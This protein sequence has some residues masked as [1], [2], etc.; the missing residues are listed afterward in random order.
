MK[1]CT[2]SPSHKQERKEENKKRVVYIRGASCTHGVV[3]LRFRKHP[4]AHALECPSLRKM[5]SYGNLPYNN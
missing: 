4:E 5:H 2:L 1:E 3:L